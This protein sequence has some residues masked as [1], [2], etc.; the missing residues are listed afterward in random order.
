MPGEGISGQSLQITGGTISGGRI[1]GA[2]ASFPQEIALTSENT[3]TGNQRFEGFIG[4]GGAGT[5][6]SPV[7]LNTVQSGPPIVESPLNT[8]VIPF[9]YNAEFVGNFTGLGGPSP[10]WAIGSSLFV[11][12]G[13]A[14]GDGAGLKVIQGLIVGAAAMSPNTNLEVL[15]GASVAA[16]FFGAAAA[17]KIGS[18][19][20][21]RVTKPD[22]FEGA[23][24]GE[25]TGNLYGLFIEN[26][27]ESKIPA[28][29]KFS[30]FVAGGNSR[31]GGPVEVSGE[32]RNAAG[33]ALVIYS[34]EAKPTEGSSFTLKQNGGGGGTQIKMPTEGATLEINNG[35]ETLF[36]IGRSGSIGWGNPEDT[37]LFRS[38]AKVLKTNNSFQVGETFRH[39]GAEAGFFNHAAAAQPKEVAATP[40]AIIA[41]LKTIGIFG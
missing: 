25:V 27:G 16:T 34:N 31:F 6:K 5:I 41:A 24:A 19:E 29:A 2:T 14:E 40:E 8:E 4:K 20:S 10:G 21:L 37:S 7:N 36:R 38:A 18:M 26:A 39:L 33:G 32:I 11:R 13:A 12:T 15:R 30:L 28:A 23:I 35:V 1:Y 3:F 22:R 17:G 9:N